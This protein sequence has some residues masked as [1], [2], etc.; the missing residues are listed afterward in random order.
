MASVIMAYMSHGGGSRL[1][2]SYLYSRPG[3]IFRSKGNSDKEQCQVEF[4]GYRLLSNANGD[5]LGRTSANLEVLH[6][7]KRKC[8][9]GS[10]SL[11]VSPFWR[12]KE[13]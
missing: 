13:N 12:I 9:V 3:A 6:D 7:Y 11:V 4:T 8:K 2:I 5:G 10:T 1:C